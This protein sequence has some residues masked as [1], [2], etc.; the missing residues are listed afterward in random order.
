M[1][2]QSSVTDPDAKPWTVRRRW[3]PWRR[4]LPLR[5]V[6][7]STPDGDKPGEDAKPANEDAESESSR[8]PVV[9]AILTII[10]LLLWLVITAGKT[11]QIVLAA[12]L[13]ITLSLA[14][15]ILQLL[16]LPFVLLARA[17]GVMRWPIQVE[18]DHHSSGPSLPTDSTRPPSCATTSPPRFSLAS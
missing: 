5:S 17:F 9:N 4:A 11:A 7:H 1:A 10:G 14:D 2:G 3:F 16:V 8:N 18:R 12:V 6:W 15:L 13:V